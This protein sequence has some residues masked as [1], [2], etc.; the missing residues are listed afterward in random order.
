VSPERATIMR[1]LLRDGPQLAQRFNWHSVRAAVAAGHIEVIPWRRV[2]ATPKG[3]L[4]LSAYADGR[5]RAKMREKEL[6]KR[7]LE[8]RGQV[9]ED[10]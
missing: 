9:V 4:A 8:A 5:W 2:E 6:W 10:G 7:A 3:K 1:I